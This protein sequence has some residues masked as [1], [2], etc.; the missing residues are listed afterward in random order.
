MNWVAVFLLAYTHF[1]F[2]L[3]NTIRAFRPDRFG[4]RGKWNIPICIVAIA[5]MLLFTWIPTVVWP[6]KDKCFGDLVWFTM[7]FDIP[8]IAIVSVSIFSMLLLAAL[9]GVR[10]LKTVN[11]DPNERIASSRM[12]FYMIL[13]VVIYVSLLNP[14]ARCDANE[15]LR[16]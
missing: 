9:L 12:V 15:H 11:I 14:L 4:P 5:V 13:T 7:P 8:A 2:G 1:V 16:R 3:E 10:L 6:R